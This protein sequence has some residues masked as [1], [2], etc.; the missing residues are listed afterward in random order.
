ME[1]IGDT[2]HFS[3]IYI[4]HIRSFNLC[5]KAGNMHSHWLNSL[6]VYI[7]ECGTRGQE[8]KFPAVALG[9]RANLGSLGQTAQIQGSPKRKGMGNH[10]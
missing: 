9:R 4:I 10:F 5:P 7:S 2:N 6:V 1:K 3:P 8:F